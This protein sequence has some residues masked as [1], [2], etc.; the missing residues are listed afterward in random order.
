MGGFQPQLESGYEASPKLTHVADSEAWFN[1]EHRANH[2][3][4]QM[5]KQ[6]NMRLR[7]ATFACAQNLAANGL[8][9]NGL[10]EGVVVRAEGCLNTDQVSLLHEA[11]TSICGTWL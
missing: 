3:L 7:G 8:R 4:R 9:N 11:T 1:W 5:Q 6:P 10:A 2:G